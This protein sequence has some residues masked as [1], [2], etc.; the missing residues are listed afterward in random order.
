MANINYLSENWLQNLFRWLIIS[1]EQ[2]RSSRLNI[3]L[4]G[5][6]WLE[7]YFNQPGESLSI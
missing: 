5:E 6:K 1:L 7:N 4:D 2:S 3:Q